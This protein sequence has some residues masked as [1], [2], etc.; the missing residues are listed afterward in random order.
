MVNLPLVGPES[1]K[2]KIRGRK[3]KPIE[4]QITE[5]DTQKRGV[6]KLDA[7]LANKP[8]AGRGLPDCPSRLKGRAR[9][10]WG[11][12]SEELENN[13]IDY[14]ISAGV[15]QGLCVTQAQAESADDIIA[16]SGQILEDPI[17][18]SEQEVVG[19]RL[20]AN[21]AVAIRNK[22]WEMVKGFASEFGVT[23]ASLERITIA[24]EDGSELEKTM[25]MLSKPRAAKELT[26]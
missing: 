9:E 20:K 4:V 5:G 19:T 17:L 24:Q 6:H 3:P 16:A 8:H 25:A 13:G 11:F 23:P 18:N 2:S 1:G 14:R 12:Y 7:K 10:L 15:L 26:Q 22:A 21:P